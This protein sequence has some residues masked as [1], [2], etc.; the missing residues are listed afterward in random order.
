MKKPIEKRNCTMIYRLKGRYQTG[1]L[2][3][4]LELSSIHN[5]SEL[6]I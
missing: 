1:W 6:A 2:Q 3:Y 4:K 5:L